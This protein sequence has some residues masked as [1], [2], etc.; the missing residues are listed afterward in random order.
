MQ[1]NGIFE[2]QQ[3]TWWGIVGEVRGGERLTLQTN[4]K[5]SEK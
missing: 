1:E 2:E 3:A 5:L 4:G